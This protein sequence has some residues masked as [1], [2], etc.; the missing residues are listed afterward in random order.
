MTSGNEEDWGGGV[1]TRLL[2]TGADYWS[3]QPVPG[4]GVIR[5]ADGPHGLRVQDDDHPDHLG[6]GRSMPATCFPPAVTLASSWDPA[7]V[8]AVGEALGR[9]ARAAGVHVILGPGMNIKRS[10]LCGRNFEY[11][12]EDPFLSGVLA[13]AMVEGLQSQGVGACVKHFVANN[14]ESDRM[15]VSA[16]IDSRPLREIYLR[17]FEITIRRSH[18]WAVMSAYNRVNGVHASQDAWLLTS[19][20][21]H[22]WAYDGVVVSDWGAVHDPAVA[23]CAGLDVRMPGRPNDSRLE[24]AEIPEEILVQVQAR[25]TRLGKRTRL[26]P[27]TSDKGGWGEPTTAGLQV[28]YDSHHQLTRRVAAESA[29]LLQNNGD[30][31]PLD[32]SSK[33]RGVALIGELAR[34]PRYQGAGSS[35]VNPTRV[36][37]VL[38][39]ANQ[40]LPAATFASG[41]ALDADASAAEGSPEV[42][43]PATELVRA[44][45]DAAEAA[46][47]VVLFLGLPDSYEAEGSDRTHINLPDDQLGLLS[48]VV[49]VNARVV[50]A[51]SNGSIVRTSPWRDSVAAIVEFGLTGQAHGESVLDVLL[52]DVPPSGKLAETVPVRLADSP[53]YLD[54]PGENGHV[55]YGEGLYVGYR[56]YDTRQMAVDFPFGHGLSYTQFGYSDM[57]VDVRGPDDPVVCTVGITVTNDGSRAGAEVVQVYISDRSAVVTS[58]SQELAAFAKIWLGPG[59]RQ[60]IT[61]QIDRIDLQRYDNELGWVFYP[62]PREIR[63]GSSSRDIRLTRLEDL[64][65]SAVRRPVTMWSTLGE[66]TADDELGPAL[67]QLLQRRGGVRG[68]A[69]DLLADPTGRNAVLGQPVTALAEFPGFPVDHDDLRHILSRIGSLPDQGP[70]SAPG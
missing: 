51:L 68:R 70:A 20:L 10:P 8:R 64:P 13:A 60:R 55:R 1:D 24:N 48:A 63:V 59:D 36:V 56:Y 34:T 4:V 40:R 15:R 21:R 18:P 61:L 26:N 47:V 28:D 30:V 5:F 19:L 57:Q 42:P 37:S 49:Q 53:S 12:S 46:E 52:G 27:E 31:L 39:A 69:G 2:T 38:D 65:G 25:L 29:V 66:W 11:F 35:R 22:E 58:P 54:F 14:Q 62:G 3:T 17:N 6:I 32:A 50:V 16:D 44:A 7:L 43:R 33:G 9:E 23:A 67:W 45:V 41:Y